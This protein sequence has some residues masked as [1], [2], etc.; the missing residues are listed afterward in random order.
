MAELLA[1]PYGVMES[2]SCSA[3]SKWICISVYVSE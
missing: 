2:E 1:P 3:D